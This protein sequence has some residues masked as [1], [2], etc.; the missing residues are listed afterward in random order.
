MMAARDSVLFS[1]AF[2]PGLFQRRQRFMLLLRHLLRLLDPRR[3]FLQL[4]LRFR[5]VI[6]VLAALA[7]PLVALRGQRIELR[8][9]P[10]ARFDHELDLRFQAADFGIGLV[11]M[12]LRLVHAVARAIVRLPHVFQFGFDVAQLRGLPLQ[13]GL[14]LFDV[15]EKFFLL[16]L[17]FVLAQQPQQLLLFFLVGLQFAEFLR[18]RGLRLQLFQVGIQFAQDVFHP[19][20]DFRACRAAGFRFRA[21]APCISRRRPL[22]P[23]K[24]ATLPGA[25]R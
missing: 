16:A 24:S 8:L 14:R 18:H 13:I 12:V 5:Q 17:R 15:A 22:P 9:Q 1:C 10:V 19:R 3:V 23:G 2:A 20:S 4:Q 7:L 6:L 11:Q 21:G 25:L